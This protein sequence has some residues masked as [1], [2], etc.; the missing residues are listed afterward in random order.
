MNIDYLNQKV[1]LCYIVGGRCT[2]VVERNKTRRE[3][4]FTKRKLENSTH[5]LGKLVYLE[6]GTHKY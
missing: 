3:L 6:T 1:D 4:A 5:K 2:E